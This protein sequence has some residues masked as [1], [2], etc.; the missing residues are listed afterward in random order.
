MLQFGCHGNIL[1]N[2]T[3]YQPSYCCCLPSPENKKENAHHLRDVAQINEQKQKRNCVR[4]ISEGIFCLRIEDF[5]Q[6]QEQI[7]GLPGL[8]VEISHHASLHRHKR[9]V[10]LK[11]KYCT[12]SISGNCFRKRVGEFILLVDLLPF[13][14]PF[15]KAKNFF[16]FSLPQELHVVV[17]FD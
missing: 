2:S 5:I 7:S 12:S 16:F 10:F 9:N 11:S 1:P 6:K 17:F 4:G 14:V 3:L 13:D 8:L 15:K